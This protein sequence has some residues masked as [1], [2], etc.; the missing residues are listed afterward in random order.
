MTGVSVLDAVYDI[1]RRMSEVA[2]SGKK[3]IS[4]YQLLFGQILVSSYCRYV[5]PHE[6]SSSRKVLE[7]GSGDYVRRRSLTVISQK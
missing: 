2:Q 7:I 5:K 4:P 3:D 1:F 6:S